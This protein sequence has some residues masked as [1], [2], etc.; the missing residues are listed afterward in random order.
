MKSLPCH[1]AEGQWSRRE[2]ALSPRPAR[3]RCGRAELPPAQPRSSCSV[4][5]SGAE[6][7]C[8]GARRLP[9]PC[10][11]RCSGR[12]GCWPPAACWEPR[13]AAGTA[14]APAGTTRAGPPAPAGLAATATRTASG[15]ETAARTTPPRAAVPRWAVP[16][17]PGGHG[18]GAAPRAGLAAGP[19]AARSRCRP[20]TAGIPV[21]TS[22]SAAAAWGSTRPAARPKVT[23]LPAALLPAVSVC[24]PPG[25][26]L[27]IPVFLTAALVPEV[28]KILPSSFSQ[29]FRGPWR[30][31][32]PPLLEEPSG[33]C[34]YFRL[35]Q[36]GPRC[37]G[38]AWSRR[39]Q[40]DQQVC[41]EC[42]GNLPHRRPH[43][44][45]HGLQG[46]R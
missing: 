41:V 43:C 14:A 24:C 22:S 37:R 36:V 39:L 46:A 42:R 40:R 21:L 3:G 18:A 27:I 34:G 25:V 19:A 31:A 30:R 16:W 44:T 20:G 32:G 29:D 12:A 6:P 35:T 2:R 17:G 15:P 13:A 5:C 38:H 45:G 33:S 10:G 4:R 11:A 26:S 28:A 1:G 23:G 9:V 8:R 7:S